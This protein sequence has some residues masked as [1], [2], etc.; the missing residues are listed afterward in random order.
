[1]V[2]MN[3]DFLSN[4]KSF[5]NLYK[6]CKQAEDSVYSTPE[7]SAISCRKALECVIKVFYFA[8]FKNVPKDSTL[9][10]LT[11]DGKFTCYFDE[12]ILSCI[13]Y[14]RKIG[15]NGAHGEE[16]TSKQSIVVLTYLHEVIIKILGSLNLIRSC[17]TFDRSLYNN[18]K[19]SS[20]ANDKDELPELDLDEIKNIAN[21][22]SISSKQ[23]IASSLDI[24]EAETR[25]LFIDEDL[26][27][28]GWKFANNADIS[29]KVAVEYEIKGMPNNANK[30]YADY[31]L[32]DD[33]ETVLAII[34]AKKLN[35][36]E[37]VG[38]QQAKLYADCIERN[39]QKRPIVFYTNGSIIKIVDNDG[40]PS[41]RVFGYYSKAELHS[42]LSREIKPIKESE[43]HVDPQI[44]DRYFIQN[45]ATAVCEAFNKKKR[46]ALIVMATGT[47][48]TRCAISL[49][50]ILQRC[51][52]AKRVLF[53]AD[54]TAL[55]KQAKNAFMNFLPDSSLSVLSENDPKNR[56]FN[57]RVTL[58]TYQTMIRVINSDDKQIGIAHYDL[59]IADECHRSIYNKYQ[60]IFTYF[61]SLVLGLT[62]TPKEQVDNST[63]DIFNLPNGEPTF[64]YDY[65]TAVKEGFLVDFHAIE[66]KT[67]LIKNDL[68]YSD[69]S[70]EERQKYENLF[71]EEGELPDRIVG[72]KFYE[73]I[74][75]D[76]TVDLVLQTIIDQGLKIN[77]GETLGKTIIFAA[78]HEHA[79]FIVER[80][81]ELY[82]HLGNDYCKL[83][84]NTINYAQTLI[85]EFSI[86][87]NSFRIAVS[88]D[89]LD[90][91]ID[92]PEVCN[93]V[94][95]K[96][97]LSKIKF[98]QMIGRGTRTCKKLNVFSP[99]KIFFE[100]NSNVASEYKE[101]SDKQG[102]YIFDFC[103][104]FEFFRMHI[105][106]RPIEDSLSLTQRIFTC[107]VD[108]VYELQKLVHQENPDHKKYYDLYKNELLN[109]I[110][111]LNRN[112]V[113]VKSN[114][115]YVYKYS[116]PHAWEY[117]SIADVK[118]IQ[119]YISP[120]VN[121]LDD[122]GEEKTLDLWIFKI[123][124][125]HICGD[126]DYSKNAQK[127]INVCYNLLDMTTIP[128]IN[129]KKDELKDFVKEDYWENINLNNLENLRETLRELI[130][131]L[132]KN[133][134][135]Y[136]HSNFEDGLIDC[137]GGTIIRPQ[138]KN[139][140][141]RVIDYLMD[142]KNSGAIKKITNL[143]PLN[144]DDINELEKI[145]CHDLGTKDE[146]DDL[147]DG[148]E[149]PVFVRKIVGLNNETIVNLFSKYLQKY[150]F[151]S[152]Q[153]DFLH[154]IVEFVIQN[155][156]I[157][158]SD[159]YDTNPFKNIQYDN[160]FNETGPFY[161]FVSIFHNVLNI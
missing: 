66:K 15:N 120:L 101:Y 99:S 57:S 53:L 149:L 49:V 134:T 8:N 96:K 150:D 107:K 119:K 54:R 126:V 64:S 70:E 41:R 93:L 131:F 89:M 151:N 74:M 2:I 40:Y 37:V 82:Q 111:K 67:N 69:L 11:T 14:I 104:V 39:G 45:A 77:G 132:E 130:K 122:N 161:E 154:Q 128:Q 87:D 108:I 156:D 114:I 4:E 31:A 19:I 63:Y 42:I 12:T 34:E 17:P 95:F 10:E 129:V 71:D 102:F 55:V 141:Q 112:F 83:I 86:P 16:V 133:K 116:N 152:Q 78:N 97:V 21:K 137:K 52:W 60:A 142:H 25:K 121:P 143:E 58:S 98:W 30:G 109:K 73:N 5:N 59:I 26:K 7:I 105:D 51:K 106:L 43:M 91:G 62:A 144:E 115:A 35:V 72:N 79:K 90:T 147:S 103:G 140:K 23:K 1:M 28:A 20:T 127:I 92:V 46:K 81:N 135:R 158:L 22:S 9:F 50:D 148:K 123:E 136:I 139:Y 6:F 33:D 61:D 18:L 153:Q 38:S 159:L 80:F 157:E 155:G 146:F 36:D 47:G 76:K 75:N 94:F 145:L 56:D 65:E 68:I 160:Y 84:D 13:N 27:E 88:V 117:I 125:A 113:N 48:K 85:D 29:G 44:S 24:S 110:K 3:F 100:D 138:F 118:E 124:L 32:I